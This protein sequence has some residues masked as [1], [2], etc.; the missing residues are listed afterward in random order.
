V[1]VPLELL[2][3]YVGEYELQP[4]FIIRIFLEGGQLMTQATGQA[5]FPVY[6]SSQTRFFLKVVDAEIE[7]IRNESGKVDSLILYQEGQEF[8]CMKK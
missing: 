4:G 3:E 1:T 8:K 5:A 7:F 2:N 6:A